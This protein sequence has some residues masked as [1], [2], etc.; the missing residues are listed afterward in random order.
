MNPR[1]REAQDP[2]S[3]GVGVTGARRPAIL[4]APELPPRIGHSSAAAG[5]GG[6]GGG[7]IEG[8]TKN[9]KWVSC[10][11]CKAKVRSDLLD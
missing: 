1:T 5:G 2:A 3:G 4:C 6:G 8:I 10:S 11:Q 9:D 7:E